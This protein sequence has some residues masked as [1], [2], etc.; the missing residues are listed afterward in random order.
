VAKTKRTTRKPVK[1]VAEKKNGKA[2]DTG[3]LRRP[4]L[5]SVGALALAEEQASDMIDS[6]LDRGEKARKAGEKYMKKEN[7]SKSAKKKPAAKKKAFSGE[8]LLGR[9]LHWLNIPTRKDIEKLNRKVDSL[10]KKV[11]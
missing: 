10:L 9:A 6:L 8:E 4:F 2:K 11:A 5:I 3:L 7:A 1:A